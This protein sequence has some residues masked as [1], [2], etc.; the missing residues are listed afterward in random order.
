MNSDKDSI[1]SID[2]L[3]IP[4]SSKE[5]KTAKNPSAKTILVA[6]DEEKIRRLIAKRL[7]GEGYNIEEAANGEEALKIALATSIDLVITDLK[8]PKMNGWRLLSMLRRRDLDIPVIIMTGYVPEEGQKL[9]TSKEI[10][11][12]VT[13]PID[14][15]TLSQMVNN[16]FSPQSPGRK[17]RVLAIDDTGDTLLL[18][19]K[20]L[21]Q[22]GF[23]IKTAQNG[24]DALKEV[25]RFKPDLLLLDLVMPQMDGFE[26][27][28]HLRSQPASAR[29]PIILLTAK[30]SGEDVKKAVALKVAG[31]IVKPFKADLLIT[32]IRKVLQGAG[33]L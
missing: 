5:K 13:K 1:D 14:F 29:L 30:T 23:E 15:Q 31:Y 32:R 33:K 18:I 11:G 28:R 7:A 27:C 24:H 6:E 16:V 19:S 17:L 9:L 26:V 4:A 25:D 10:V 22:A 2:S 3:F 20:H 8:M 12:F 21:Q